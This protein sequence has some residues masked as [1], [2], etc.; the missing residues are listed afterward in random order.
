MAGD[1]SIIKLRYNMF[2]SS[3][4]QGAYKFGKM[5]FPEF[6]SLSRPSKQSFPLQTKLKADVANHF[7]SHFGI[8]LAELQNIFLRSMVTGSTHASSS[9]HK[10]HYRRTNVHVG[11][12]VSDCV[13]KKIA[14]D[15]QKLPKYTLNSLSFPELTNSVRFPGLSEL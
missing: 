8:F 2:S 9:S 5:K 6:S 4:R 15:I 1:L 10:Y 13:T 7:S 3:R 11:L 12:C 14:S